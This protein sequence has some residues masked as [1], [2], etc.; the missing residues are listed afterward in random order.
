[1]PAGVEVLAVCLHRHSRSAQRTK[2][3]NSAQSLR[4]PRAWNR[5][6]L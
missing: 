3:A 4:V 2:I 1:M 6:W 5:R